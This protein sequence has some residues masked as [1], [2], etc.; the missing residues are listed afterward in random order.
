MLTPKQQQFLVMAAAAAVESETKTKLPAAFCLSQAIFES[1]WGA[2]C[3]GNNCFGIKPDHHGA[4]VQYF[5]SH[6][7]LSGKWQEM[8]MAFEKYNSLADCFIDHARLVTEGAPYKQAWSLFLQDHDVD[9]LVRRVCPVYGTDP[10][11]TEKI[12][13]EMKSL[14]VTQAIASARSM[15]T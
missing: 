2:R 7:F 10:K 9:G 5:V 4:G 15:A 8:E 14:S 12:E 1:G 6:E 11:Y 13:G 3:P